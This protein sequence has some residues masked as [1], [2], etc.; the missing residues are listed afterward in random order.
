MGQSATAKFSPATT[1]C[2]SWTGDWTAIITQFAQS[3]PTIQ[4][5]ISL[6][7]GK[8]FPAAARVQWRNTRSTR[9][10]SFGLG[11]DASVLDDSCMP[12][13]V[14]AVRK[15]TLI[16]VCSA[17]HEASGS[18]FAYTASEGALPMTSVMAAVSARPGRSGF[19]MI[20]AAQRRRPGARSTTGV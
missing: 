9:R 4:G 17:S 2:E 19:D 15:R 16:G 7:R 1:K 20:R 13:K 12:P 10:R 8:R 18:S 3:S 14:H 11:D 5:S 6:R